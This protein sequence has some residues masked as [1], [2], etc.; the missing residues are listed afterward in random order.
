MGTVCLNPTS[1]GDM[2]IEWLV[3]FDMGVEWAFIKGRKKVVVDWL[4]RRLKWVSCGCTPYSHITST[5][6]FTVFSS[7]S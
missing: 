3:S 7:H 5:D 2:G 4:S 1:S 6:L